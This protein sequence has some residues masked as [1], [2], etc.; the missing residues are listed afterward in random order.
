MIEHII[1]NIKNIIN[2]IY[3]LHRNLYYIIYYI[4]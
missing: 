2:D 4:I 1:Y 3:I